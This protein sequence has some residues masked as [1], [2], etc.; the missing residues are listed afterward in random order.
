[1]RRRSK[2]KSAISEDG[3]MSGRSE[4]I[5]ILNG[6]CAA[7]PRSRTQ[8]DAKQVGSKLFGG[9]P[10]SGATVPFTVAP[11]QNH[12]TGSMDPDSSGGSRRRRKRHLQ[13]P[14]KVVQKH[15]RGLKKNDNETSEDGQRGQERESI[16]ILGVF[17]A[18][19]KSSI[20]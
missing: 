1:M 11:C 10:A 17:C 8:R 2:S 4:S 9:P 20:L 3:E 5:V 14:Q 15:I 19:S 12:C 13:A 18:V 7:S 16:V 6:I